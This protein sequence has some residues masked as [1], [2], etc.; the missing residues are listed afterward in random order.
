[1]LWQRAKL[2][3]VLEPRI[4]AIAVLLKSAF[5]SVEPWKCGEVP[6]LKD[7]VYP[8]HV[9]YTWSRLDFRFHYWVVNC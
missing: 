4:T 8:I 6:L 3:Y 5:D 2:S 7:Y 1:M 9:L